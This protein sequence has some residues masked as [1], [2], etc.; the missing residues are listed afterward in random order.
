MARPAVSLAFALAMATSAQAQEARNANA[1]SMQQRHDELAKLKEKLADP[2]PL[3][4]VASMEAMV[5]SGDATEMNVA[6]RAALASNDPS[7]RNLAM[8][9]WVAGLKRLTVDIVLPGDLQKR[10]EQAEL[11]PKQASAL[12][13]TNKWLGAWAAFGFQASFAF[14]DI[15]VSKNTGKVYSI[16]G[17]DERYAT[18]FTIS[19]TQLFITTALSFPAI[20]AVPCSFRLSPAADVTLSGTVSCDFGY[21]SPRLAVTGPML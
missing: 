9:S 17:Q 21:P 7:L 5:A 19:G 14:V 8:R 12:F 15:D 11:D 18:D 16:P 6:I 4:R 1:T 3:V 2:D 10:A 20:N 13:T